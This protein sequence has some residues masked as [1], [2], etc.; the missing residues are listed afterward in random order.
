MFKVAWH[1]RLVLTT[2]AEQTEGMVQE[3]KL[4]LG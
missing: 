3:K 4:K 1:A 2:Q